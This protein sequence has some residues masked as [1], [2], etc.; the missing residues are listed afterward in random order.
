MIPD[1]FPVELLESIIDLSIPK[2][3]ND[4]RD[5]PLALELRL[6]CSTSRIQISGWQRCSLIANFAELFDKIASRCAFRK[7]NHCLLESQVPRLNEC[8][9]TWLLVTKISIET[10]IPYA[11]ITA[12]LR[13]AAQSMVYWKACSFGLSVCE[14]EYW[15]TACAVVVAYQG[16]NWVCEQLKVSF[17]DAPGPS[18]RQAE[19]PTLYD[20]LL[21][22]AYHGDRSIVETLLRE[23]ADVNA[24]NGC[25]GYALYAAAY[26]GNTDIVGVLLEHGA[27]VSIEGVLGTPLHVAAYHDY[28]Q[29]T[30]LLLAHFNIDPIPRIHGARHRFY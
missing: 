7:L 16:K 30:G 26:R 2:F 4:S 27:D 10:N 11:D 18:S 9:M 28:C 3:W 12:A 8:N 21:I 20:G 13:R 5:G 24:S 19:C 1:D 23:G 14:E 29:V 6:V 22:A 17:D 25:L 15:N